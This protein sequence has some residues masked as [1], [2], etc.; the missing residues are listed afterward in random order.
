M[1]QLNR[2]L[3]RTDRLE[4]FSNIDV[5]VTDLPERILQ[6]GTGVLLR[7]LPLYFI[8]KANRAGVFNGRVVVVKS[9]DQ[10]GTDAFEAQDGLYTLHIQGVENG[11]EIDEAMLI[12]AISRVLPASIAWDKIL[13]VAEDPMVEIVISNTTEVGIVFDESDSLHSEPPNSFPAKL[14]ALLYRRF[15]HFGGDLAKGWVILPTELISDNGKKLKDIVLSLSHKHGLGDDFIYWLERAND[16]CTTLVD[17]IVP[18]KYPGSETPA[19]ESQWG[20]RDALAIKAEPF[21]LWAMEPATDRIKQRMQFAGVDSGLVIVDDITKFKE[22]KLRLLNGTHTFSCALALLCGFETVK[23]AMTNAVFVRFVENL[24]YREIAPTITGGMIQA[25][26][27]TNFAQAVIDRFSNPF[28]EH[29]WLSISVNY[30]TKMRMRNVP[31]LNE[32]ATRMHG[33]PDHMAL[34]FAAYLRFMKVEKQSDG[35]YEG[36]INGQY[37]SVDDEHAPYFAEMWKNSSVSNLVITVLSAS[38]LWGQDLTLFPGFVNSVTIM[39][40]ELLA[41]NA[42]DVID[43]VS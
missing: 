31:L 29:Q 2:S 7:G 35:G 19:Y 22:L 24:M 42:I 3:L 16:F 32:Y 9:T 21:R 18:G 26:E 38:S 41:N 8:E 23:E 30:T 10:G 28:L 15:Q 25:E 12:S 17:R 40:E 33:V 39:L 43:Q 34:G 20:Y 27:A 11:E 5:D 13:R 4:S 14:T 6:F 36:N 1:T 37:Y